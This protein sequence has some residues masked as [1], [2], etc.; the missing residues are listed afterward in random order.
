MQPGN[1]KGGMYHCTVDLLFNRFG[2][3]CFANKNKT[4]QL[5]YSR[6]QTS[7]TGGEPYSD[8]SPFGIPCP[9]LH[10]ESVLGAPV[11]GLVDPEAALK[12]GLDVV[13]AVQLPTL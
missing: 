8:A 13:D 4:C 1:T 6:F 12:I 3:V 2:L 9:I 11:S 5:S 10:V 7:Q